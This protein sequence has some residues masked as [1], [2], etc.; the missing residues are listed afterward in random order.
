M[1]V[2]TVEPRQGA[3]TRAVAQSAAPEVN[4]ASKSVPR[5]L[6][7]GAIGFGL[8]IGSIALMPVAGPATL[9]AAPLALI[10]FRGCPTCW[11][12]GLAQTISR[13][14]LERQCVDGVCTLTKAHTAAKA[15]EEPTSDITVPTA[16]R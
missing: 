16:L 5:H 2:H 4:F 12:V 3:K 6:A 15:A 9:L 8:I 7:R 13:G 11:M 14:R 1:T 10:A